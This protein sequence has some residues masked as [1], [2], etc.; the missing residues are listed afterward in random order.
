MPNVTTRNRPLALASTQLFFKQIFILL[1][2]LFKQQMVSLYSFI[3]FLFILPTIFAFRNSYSEISNSLNIKL[4]PCRDFY[5]F[6]CDGFEKKI[7]V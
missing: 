6:V 7:K 4:D 1:I 2:S 5:K 3:K